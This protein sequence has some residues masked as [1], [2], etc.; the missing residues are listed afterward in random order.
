MSAMSFL[1]GQLVNFTGVG[2]RTTEATCAKGFFPTPRVYH[3]TYRGE[4][5]GGREAQE[6]KGY[7]YTHS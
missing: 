5:R 6:G 4:V 3:T 2:V 1:S 7:S